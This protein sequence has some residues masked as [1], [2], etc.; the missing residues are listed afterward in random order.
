MN[1]AKSQ[2]GGLYDLAKQAGVVP[3]SVQQAGDVMS[4]IPPVPVGD[5]CNPNPEA[6]KIVQEKLV[7]L[8]YDP[9]PADGRYTS[10]TRQVVRDYYWHAGT[11]P[12]KKCPLDDGMV[13]YFAKYNNPP[14]DFAGPN[15][16]CL[17]PAPASYT[18]QCLDAHAQIL[19][20]CDPSLTRFCPKGW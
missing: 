3:D 2:A 19:G 12:A 17:G 15:Y 16:K 13:A 10:K 6:V 7:L 5:P 20:Q 9:G 1:Q 14:E 11:Y 8:G 4:S 18:D